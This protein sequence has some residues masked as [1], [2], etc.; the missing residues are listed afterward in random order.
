[1]K[2]SLIKIKLFS[3]IHL[4]EI[5][6]VALAFFGVRAL[7]KNTFPFQKEQKWKWNIK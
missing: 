7:Q 4:R 1:M 3:L 5:F 2:I 6:F